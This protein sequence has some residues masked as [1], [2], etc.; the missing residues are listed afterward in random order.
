MKN[1]LMNFLHQILDA[2]DVESAATG[3]IVN[4]WLMHEFTAENLL[5][6]SA[7]ALDS[8]PD[9]VMGIHA[10]TLGLSRKALDVDPRSI[11]CPIVN[12]GITAATYGFAI[13]ASR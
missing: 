9:P 5:K 3:I 2:S 12:P 8:H 10:I 6:S 13:M 4:I 11:L 7:Q 1:G